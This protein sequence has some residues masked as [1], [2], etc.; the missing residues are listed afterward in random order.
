MRHFL[1]TLVF[2]ILFSTNIYSQV[3]QNTAPLKSGFYSVTLDAFKKLGYKL[4]DSKE[5]Y[6]IRSNTFLSLQ[7]IDTVFSRYDEN[8][9]CFLISYKFNK[10]GTDELFDFT[11]TLLQVQAKIG[12]VINNKLQ[13]VA[14][15]QDPIGYGQMELASN[16]SKQKIDSLTWALLDVIKKSKP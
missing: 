6:F 12:L 16:F 4:Q 5:F 3:R 13:L 11:K 8:F 2:S 10:K 15:I 9:K 14:T 1:S 7:N